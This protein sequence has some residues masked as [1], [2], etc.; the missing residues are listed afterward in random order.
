M[1]SILFHEAAPLLHNPPHNSHS[2]PKRMKLRSLLFFVF[3]VISF[4]SF[5]L[6]DDDDDDDDI[7]NDA[8]IFPSA[9]YPLGTKVFKEFPCGWYVGTISYHNIQE[10]T[11]KVIYDDDF[12]TEDYSG[13]SV[14]LA[15]MVQNAES[16]EP[17]EKGQPVVQP[18]NGGTTIRM[19][20][21]QNC[22]VRFVK[23]KE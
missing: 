21:I 2:L 8:T 22:T 11:Y 7:H 6:C 17:Y 13:N 18:L 23:K 10:D 9:E 15:E 3:V 16:Y 4:S 20:Y 12:D 14:E 1:Q 19:G 5:V